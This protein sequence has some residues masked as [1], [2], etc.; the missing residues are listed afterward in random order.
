M[1]APR[2]TLTEYRMGDSPSRKRAPGP[3]ST[4]LAQY[5]LLASAVMLA[6]HRNCTRPRVYPARFCEY[7]SESLANRLTKMP[8]LL[9]SANQPRAEPVSGWPKPF[10]YETPP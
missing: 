5:W 9:V 8:S 4:K 7:Q 2:S 6:F 10:E 3:V 1:Y